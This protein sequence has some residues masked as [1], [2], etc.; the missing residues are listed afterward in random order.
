MPGSGLPEDQ[1]NP[2]GGTKTSSI[3]AYTRRGRQETKRGPVGSAAGSGNE[4]VDEAP[5]RQRPA[6]LGAAGDQA[7]RGGAKTPPVCA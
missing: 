7:R 5:F 4:P 6:R 3:R 1:S 2:V